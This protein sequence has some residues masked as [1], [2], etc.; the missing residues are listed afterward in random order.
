MWAIWWK[1][2]YKLYTVLSSVGVVFLMCIFVNCICLACIVVILCI[3]FIL[4]VFVILCKRQRTDIGK[5][6]FVNRT[7]EDWNQ[8][9]AEVL[10][11]LPCKLSTLKERITKAIIGVSEGKIKCAENHLKCSERK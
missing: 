2:Y 7:I 10:G 5:N 1:K 11:T 8:L 6:S 4:C 3:C 9:H